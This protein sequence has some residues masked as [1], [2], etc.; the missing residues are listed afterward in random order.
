[1]YFL[2]LSGRA[3]FCGPNDNVERV[4]FPLVEAI[5]KH[6]QNHNVPKK[7]ADI[8][9]LPYQL[10]HCTRWDSQLDED[11]T[12]YSET[13]EQCAFSDGKRTYQYTRRIE[14]Y[15]NSHDIW[16]NIGVKFEDTEARYIIG[17]IATEQT[18][19]YRQYPKANIIYIGKGFCTTTYRPIQ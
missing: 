11:S 10:E 12:G 13:I 17:K 7:T 9:G 18:L 2:F 15:K 14:F 4:A 5:V 6:M 8:N 19:Q 1:M 16:V 3:I